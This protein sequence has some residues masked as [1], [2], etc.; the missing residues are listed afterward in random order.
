MTDPASRLGQA[1]ADRY[2]IEREVGT[3]GMATVYLAEDLKHERKVA[4]KVLK[5][6]LAAVIGGER[7]VSEIK[8]TA[9]FQHPHILPLHDSGEADGFLYYVMPY[10][11]GE[12]LRGRIDR[13]KQLGV[14]EA[15]RI[16]TDVAD[17]LDYAHRSG[18]IHR[19][20]K[21]ENILLQDGRPVVADF[22]IALALSAAGGGRMT[23][24]GL[25][26]GT[27]H[28]MSPEQAT[29]D[30][31]LS[32]RSDI[33][34]LACVL[35]EMLTGD[36]P[37]TASTSQAILVRIL[38]ES[39]RSVREIRA[40]VPPHVAAAIGK[41]LEKLPADRFESAGA[42]R[43]ALADPGFT[44]VV[45][46]P[47]LS[48]EIGGAVESTPRRP[49]AGLARVLPAL[50]V[51]LAGLAAWGWFRPQE[52]PRVT[53]TDL[54][55][56]DITLPGPETVEV[57][58]D[59]STFV[60]VGTLDEK[61]MIFLRRADESEFRALAGTEGA[62]FPAF[63]PDG[64]SLFFTGPTTTLLRI[65]LSGGAPRTLVAEGAGALVPYLAN[66]GDD[67]T[68][69]FATA[70]GVFRVP[71]MGGTPV[72]VGEG[73]TPRLLPGG[74]GILVTVN[75]SSIGVYDLVADTLRTLVEEGLD[76]TYVPTGHL[77][78]AHPQGGLQ[79]IAFNLETMTV[80]GEAVPV[81]DGV[82]RTPLLG[83]YYSISEEGTL[84]YVMGR[85]DDSGLNGTRLVFANTRDGE[86]S[87]VPLEPR[88]WSYPSYS[89]DGRYVVYADGE[90]PNRAI[91]VLDLEIIG[92][93]PRQLTFEGDN[94]RPVWSPDGTRIAFSSRRGADEGWDLYVKTI[95]DDRPAE[96]VMQRPGD[97][98]VSDW[99]SEDRLVFLENSDETP[100]DI[101]MMDPSG[102]GEPV[103]YLQSEAKLVSAVVS[104]DGRLAAYRSDEGGT[105]SI[106]VRSFPEPRQQSRVS[107]G[108]ARMVRW[109]PDGRGLYYWNNTGVDTLFFA[110]IQ[111]EPTFS[112]LSTDI[113]LTGVYHRSFLD[114]HPSGEQV[115]LVNDFVD[116]FGV[117][118][119]AGH[120]AE[121]YM[122]VFNWF[123]EL[124][125]R[126]GN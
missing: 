71:E 50:T 35:Y 109:S 22:G 36:P 85:G 7:F 61:R 106:Y 63:S 37:H 88:A 89:P 21:P 66:W 31:D 29:A 110:H 117:V 26:L 115:L 108:A 112:V 95:V 79:A 99:P 54:I 126:M 17:A 101:W 80:S 42:F 97:Q 98:Y 78:F 81:L 113:V 87:D 5:P 93:T 19:D 124:R 76:A 16:T 118:S 103:P 74:R 82:G 107:M 121:R 28:Y 18:V 24:T 51:V 86:A 14:D 15:I 41:A 100:W 91:F 123:E 122:V 120:E 57:S 38:T 104:P 59:G 65:S 34:A 114:V 39:P 8:T 94:D 92:T 90:R 72:R 73:W 96:R 46:P 23:A 1:L 30:R 70:E 48:T 4:I 77:V 44:H 25:S 2:R 84:A 45:R 64:E 53:R 12:S 10:I 69:V 60:V 20:I 67:G 49:R 62:R 119:G 83:A 116:V 27:P 43:D 56:G 40:S 11:Q 52:P 3:G 102:A 13:E 33:Y 105:R 68:I 32:P 47:E 75:Q 55:L 58:P 111:T 6:E 125:A 9:R